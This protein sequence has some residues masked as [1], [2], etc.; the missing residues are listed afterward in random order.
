MKLHAIGQR[1][2]HDER[3]T[4]LGKFAPVVDAMNRRVRNERQLFED[5]RNT[6]ASACSSGVNSSCRRRSWCEI[7]FR[8][9]TP[10]VSDPGFV[11]VPC[12]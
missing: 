12:C 4:V 10:C 6:A 2:N 5:S 11:R 3:L 1:G 9:E 8:D 7:R